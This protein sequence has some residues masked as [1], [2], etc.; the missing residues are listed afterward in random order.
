MS[1]KKGFGKA[2]AKIILGGEHAVV[3]G[4]AAIVLPVPIEV[5]AYTQQGQLGQ[6]VRIESQYFKGSLDAHP[7]EL[8]GYFL[9]VEHIL[10]TLGYSIL[11]VD[12]VISVRSDIPMKSG[13]GSSAAVANAIATSLYDYY[14]DAYDQ[15][16][17]YEAV[18]VAEK[19]AHGN[20]SGLD[21]LGTSLATPIV[22]K[23][24][25][26]D[27]DSP[28]RWT[29]EP[30]KMRETLHFV[31]IISPLK[32]TTREVVEIVADKFEG[33]PHLKA[34][35]LKDMSELIDDMRL[36]F[37][38][39]RA[40]SLGKNMNR[41]Q[42]LL[43]TL[44]V[45]SESLDKLIDSA[46]EEGAL[47]AKLSGKGVGGAIIALAPS[48]RVADKIADTCLSEGAS[49]AYVLTINGQEI[50]VEEITKHA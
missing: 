18:K 32:V 21:M 1:T 28:I 34:M 37:I 22:Y 11:S 24:I 16:E 4:S 6:G 15:N 42:V 25:G 10:M 8:K 29:L 7:A 46:I 36:N 13:L 49:N 23:T 43:S 12:L 2:H 48:S 27:F 14:R 19:V 17:I 44:G 41:N 38:E 47:G 5:N 50:S 40:E 33:A 20:P 9:M 45:S 30:L 26:N 35:I 31:I 3:H 39:G